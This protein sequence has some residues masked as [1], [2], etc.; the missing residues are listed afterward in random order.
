MHDDL[1]TLNRP[2]TRLLAICG[3]CGKKLDGGFGSDNGRSLVKS[4]RQ[5]VPNAKGKR[6]TT[7]IV[8]TRCLDICPKGAVALIDSRTPGE[9]LLV[10]RGTAVEDV[11]ARLD[12]PR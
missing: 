3:K 2:A 10:R 7:R 12:L 6:A 9:V 8:E 4:L 5:I 1:R 11:V